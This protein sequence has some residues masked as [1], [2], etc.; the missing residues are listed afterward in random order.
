MATLP[1]G[2]R[3]SLTATELARLRFP[4]PGLDL[5]VAVH[6]GALRAGASS[7]LT[8]LVSIASGSVVWAGALD[9]GM[10]RASGSGPKDARTRLWSMLKTGEHLWSIVWPGPL[11]LPGQPTPYLTV[12][13]GDRPWIIVGELSNGDLVGAP[14]NDARSNPKWWTPIL[15]PDQLGFP[16]SKLSQ[17]ELGHLWSLPASVAT[18]DRLKNGGDQVVASGLAGFS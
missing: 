17:V 15:R 11:L 10:V 9:E 6:A 8:Q 3:V 16:N 4:P 13:D 12:Y 5:V 18:L 7:R 1:P 2:T 14:L